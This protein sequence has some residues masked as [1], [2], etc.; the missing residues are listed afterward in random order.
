MINDSGEAMNG[1]RD[2]LLV[3]FDLAIHYQSG[4]DAA[5]ERAVRPGYMNL[6]P[7]I[8][9][10]TR[11]FSGHTTVHVNRASKGD[12]TN[13]AY[14]LSRLGVAVLRAV[15]YLLRMLRT[16]LHASGRQGRFQYCR[17]QVVRQEESKHAVYWQRKRAYRRDNVGLRAG[18]P[19]GV[20]Q[21]LQAS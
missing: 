17:R 16:V 15:L 10:L 11:S 1:L 18:Y 12:K 6:T 14:V 7:T 3:D 19:A 20:P 13:G 8:I 5:D 4:P 21:L 2:G 9:E